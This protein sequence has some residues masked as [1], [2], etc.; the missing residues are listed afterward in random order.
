[1][2]KVL[3]PLNQ[4]LGTP[5]GFKFCCAES[6]SSLPCKHPSGEMSLALENFQNS[7]RGK[8][9]G[10]RGGSLQIWQEGHLLF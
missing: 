9:E 7:G 2:T 6:S 10:S 3:G 5:K 4:S 1:L 8:S